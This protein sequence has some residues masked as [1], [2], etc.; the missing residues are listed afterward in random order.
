[1]ARQ[2]GHFVTVILYVIE[3]T[4][5]NRLKTL[6]SPAKLRGKMLPIY[7][8]EMLNSGQNWQFVVL[9]DLKI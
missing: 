6:R 2:D 5:Y 1:M 3:T 7:S 9:C 4:C 8:L